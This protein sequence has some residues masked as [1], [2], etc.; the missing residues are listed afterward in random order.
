MQWWM[1]QTLIP[2]RPRP[3][4]THRSKKLKGPRVRPDKLH[5]TPLQVGDCGDESRRMR[6]NFS[7]YPPFCGMRTLQCNLKRDKW[8]IKVQET[9]EH[10][11]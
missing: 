7:S 1:V 8:S 4:A 6:L 10:E 3:C 2:V 5:W 11:D 9:R